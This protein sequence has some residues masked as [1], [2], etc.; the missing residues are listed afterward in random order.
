MSPPPSPAYMWCPVEAARR[1]LRTPR[2]AG[3]GGRGAACR[4]RPLS[5]CM[6]AEAGGSGSAATVGTHGRQGKAAGAALP[7]LTNGNVAT[8]TAENAGTEG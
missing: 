6:C 4:L 5:P 1:S 3:N 2:R 8:V 7:Y